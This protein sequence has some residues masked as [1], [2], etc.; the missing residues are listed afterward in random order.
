MNTIRP[1]VLVVDHKDE[2]LIELQRL[3]EN[4]GFDTTVAWS[5]QD[6]LNAAFAAKFDL[7]LINDYLPDMDFEEFSRKLYRTVGDTRCIILHPQ[8]LSQESKAGAGD[9]ARSV[10][11]TI[12]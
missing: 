2:Y 11:Q 9:Y 4:K 1:A 8:H 7:I 10:S 12:D 3:L 5:G 6:A